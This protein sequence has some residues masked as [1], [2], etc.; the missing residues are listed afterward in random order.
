MDYGGMEYPPET[1]RRSA[2]V[3][4]MKIVLFHVS[5]VAV[6]AALTE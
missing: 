4:G 6:I 2:S 5:F 1:L 3:A